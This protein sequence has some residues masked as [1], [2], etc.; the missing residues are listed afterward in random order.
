MGNG[1]RLG[2]RRR[3]VSPTLFR[4]LYAPTFRRSYFFLEFVRAAIVVEDPFENGA[5]VHLAHPHEDVD[6]T[7]FVVRLGR[8][9]GGVDLSKRQPR[10]LLRE[11]LPIKENLCDKMVEG[12]GGLSICVSV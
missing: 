10:L 5:L 7:E 4:S 9:E 12:F 1:Q 3:T 8:L 6:V 11:N 2:G